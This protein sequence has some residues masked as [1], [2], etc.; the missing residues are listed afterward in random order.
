LIDPYSKRAY[1]V[2][3]FR[4]GKVIH[5]NARKEV[6]LSAGAVNSPQILML[7][8]IGP[9]DHLNRIIF[10]IPVL[11]DLP[12]GHNLQDHI[13]VGGIIFRIEK[14]VS[15]IQPRYENMQSTLQYAVFGG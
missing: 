13:A 9:K 8:G 2:K 14:E 3:V 6:I 11:K 1:G 4:Y 7:S 15:M 12:V 5:I 10:N